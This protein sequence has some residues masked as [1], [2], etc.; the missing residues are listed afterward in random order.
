MLQNFDIILVRP[1]QSGN[2]GSVAR[3]ISNHGFRKLILVDPPHLDIEHARWMAPH[4]KHVID[5]SLY[6]SDIHLGV[7]TSHIVFGT[8]AR[9]RSWD[10]PHLELQDFLDMVYQKVQKTPDI[11]ISL[12]FGPEDSGLS[13]QDLSFCQ[14]T[15]ALPT[16][17]NASLNLGQAV[18]VFGSQILHYFCQKKTEQEIVSDVN[19]HETSSIPISQKIFHSITERTLSIL[20][21]SGYLDAKNPLQIR[22]QILRFLSQSNLSKKDISIISGMTNKVYHKLRILGYIQDD[23]QK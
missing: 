12:V 22:H 13:N 1:Q 18:N 16:V 9:R 8:T 19:E 10:I 3:S 21:G 5:E 17:E 2:V 11:R 14:Y 15:V 23:I 6:V 20:A 4:A 7:A